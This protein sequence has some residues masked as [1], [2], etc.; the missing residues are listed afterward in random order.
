MSAVVS[1]TCRRS[2]RFQHTVKARGAQSIE[3]DQKNQTR[4]Q[5]RAGGVSSGKQKTARAGVRGEKESR[6]SG[7]SGEAR[8]WNRAL[9]AEWCGLALVYAEIQRRYV[10]K[11][12]SY[13][14]SV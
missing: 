5:K 8:L 10:L 9:S 4:G 13:S 1:G 3:S 12:T 14:C 6:V 11:A 7:T 2:P